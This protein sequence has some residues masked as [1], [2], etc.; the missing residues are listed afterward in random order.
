MAKG[1]QSWRGWSPI[2]VFVT[3]TIN[4]TGWPQLNVV[5]IAPLIPGAVRRFLANGPLGKL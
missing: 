3:D 1:S 2:E 5:S 4:Q